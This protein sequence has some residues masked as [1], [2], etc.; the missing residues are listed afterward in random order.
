[1]STRRSTRGASR[2]VS[3]T[4]A[5]SPSVSTANIPPT[6]RTSARRAA[7]SLLA[8]SP[9]S[10][11]AIGA[12]QSTAYGS[13]TVPPP[14]RDGPITNR[15]IEQIIGEQVEPAKANSRASSRVSR[16]KST[17]RTSK[18]VEA[19]AAAAAAAAEE[20]AARDK[21]YVHEEGI[22]NFAGVE[23]SEPSELENELNPIEELDEPEDDEDDE[24][25]EHEDLPPNSMD[26]I[27]AAAEQERVMEIARANLA[28]GRL[29]AAR[30][31]NGQSYL[32]WIDNVKGTRFLGPLL[33]HV[34][35]NLLYYL[36]PA[37]VAVLC[38]SLT[39]R[40]ALSGLGV[41][42]PESLSN[43]GYKV[44]N[45]REWYKP[46]DVQAINRRLSDLE[47]KVGRLSTR[48][49][50][51][52]PKALEAIQDMLPD[53]LVVKKDRFGKAILPDNFWQA[54]QDKVRSKDSLLRD[55]AESV[56]KQ[57]GGHSEM[58]EFQAKKL[59]EKWSQQNE[60]EIIK[61]RDSE[62]VRQFPE[63]LKQNQVISKSEVLDLVRLNWEDNKSEIRSEMSDLTKKL[64]QATRQISK[65]QHEF[66]D[67]SAVIANEVLKNFISSGQID[68][69]AS[70]NLK[71]NVN[72]GLTRINHFSKG[73]GAIV[74]I[75]VT[76]PNYMFPSHNVWL[77]MKIAKRFIGNPIPAPNSPDTALIK[78]EEHGDCWCS[79][80]K[81]LDGFGTSLGVI[82]GS[83]I[84]AEQVV[85]EH[86]SPTAS[87]EPGAAP[88][89]MELLAW[90]SDPDLYKAVKKMS[91]AIFPD[92]ADVIQR[93]GFVL[94]GTWTY[95]IETRQNIQAFAVQ[96]DM[97]SLGAHTN[98]II[99]RS[100]NNWGAETVDYTCLYRVRVHGPIVATPGLS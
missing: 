86:I 49:S 77:P 90:I 100:K 12:R 35:K 34:F 74:D 65:L 75:T 68:A 79:P 88:K 31:R 39:S 20:E 29:H 16:A 84:Y 44:G 91:D 28:N 43:L 54:L 95:D 78:W 96:L 10:L 46:T 23:S 50:D 24:D 14:A 26:D 66:K 57:S 2:A 5:P 45:P 76:S 92:Q 82:M 27:N 25:D 3:S 51:L 94:I 64:H 59:W 9:N 97:K 58:P 99:V 42:M 38:L 63:L 30:A 93:L 19:A 4:G 37:L 21:S 18:E 48:P 40:G 73:T 55:Q 6:P 98:R 53:N 81:G 60:A 62:L 32:N 7:R 80:A 8:G 36:I 52:D 22:F 87:L 56:G 83:S 17:K 33:E 41:S 71:S 69:L 13:N 15:T 89:D 61:L 85:V 1:M 72:Y 67:K 70:A 47:W 11:P